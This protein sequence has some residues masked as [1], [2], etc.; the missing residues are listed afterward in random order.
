MGKKSNMEIAAVIYYPN[1]ISKNILQNWV[2]GR[3]WFFFH[4]YY[5]FFFPMGNIDILVLV[6]LMEYGAKVKVKSP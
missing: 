3:K 6:T 4:Y 2:A 1:L 5:F